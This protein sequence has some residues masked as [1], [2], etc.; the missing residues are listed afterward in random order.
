MHL[1]AAVLYGL[2]ALRTVLRL[3]RCAYGTHKARADNYCS[4][5]FR[6]AAVPVAALWPRWN[7]FFVI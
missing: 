7:K 5:S 2:R 3:K 6:Y 1:V 4:A